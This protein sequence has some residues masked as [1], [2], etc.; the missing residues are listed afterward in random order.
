MVVAALIATKQ[1]DVTSYCPL[2]VTTMF[3]LTITASTRLRLSA[4]CVRIRQLS[5][6][7]PRQA[8]LQHVSSLSCRFVSSSAASRCP[9]CSA[10]LPTPLPACPQCFFVTKLPPTATF[11]DIMGLPYDSNPFE[12]DPAQLKNR[13][14]ELQRVIHPDKWS[15]KGEV[16]SPL[17]CIALHSLTSLLAYR[18]FRT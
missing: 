12:V 16:R 7:I 9:S 3:R 15:N 4:S 11:Y 1:C 14:R 10:L 17:F 8:S 2:P 6:Y 5:R 13:F 18:R